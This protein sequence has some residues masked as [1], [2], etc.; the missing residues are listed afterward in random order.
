MHHTWR[1]RLLSTAITTCWARQA[2]QRWTV[3]PV[4]TSCSLIF[5]ACVLQSWIGVVQFFL[6]NQQLSVPVITA[7]LHTYSVCRVIVCSVSFGSLIFLLSFIFHRICSLSFFFLS[8]L[9]SPLVF[10]FCC[11]FVSFI[12]RPILSLFD[13]SFSFLS[14][15][16]SRSLPLLNCSPAAPLHPFFSRSSTIPSSPSSTPFSCVLLGCTLAAP[17]N[18]CV[19]VHARTRA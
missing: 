15:T 3:V 4:P 17:C 13:Q 2:E 16:L 7:H 8:L 14:F 1:L 12:V 10:I 19:K 9:C 6:P 5:L 11:S 18:I